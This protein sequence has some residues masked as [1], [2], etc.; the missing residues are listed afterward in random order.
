MG[1]AHYTQVVVTPTSSGATITWKT[2]EPATTQVAYGLTSGYG[3]TTQFNPT[4]LTSHTATITGLEPMTT[5]HYQVRSIDGAGN[6]ADL[7]DETFTTT[8]Q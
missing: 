1:G 8:S 3:Q 7:E 2:Y 5:Y 6:V 4:L